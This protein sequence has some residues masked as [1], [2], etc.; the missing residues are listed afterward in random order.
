M[1]D[2]ALQ[3]LALQAQADEYADSRAAAERLEEFQAGAPTPQPELT[4]EQQ[5]EA[6]SK[7]QAAALEKIFSAQLPRVCAV[8]WGVLDA[9]AVKYAGSEFALTPAER[10]DLVDATVPVVL[11]YLPKDLTWLVNTP[12]GALLTTAAVI[13]GAKMMAA[14]SAPA[15]PSASPPASPVTSPVEAQA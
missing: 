10:G 2:G 9:L 8:A 3:K 4:P 1:S 6:E 11:K 12:E 15:A 5:A 14:P 13:Y 7:A